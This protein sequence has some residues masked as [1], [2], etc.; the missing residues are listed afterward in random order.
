MG[1]WLVVVDAGAQMGFGFGRR[2]AA[3]GHGVAGRAMAKAVPLDA[4]Q[5]EGTA[6]A[7]A[8]R[9]AAPLFKSGPS[10]ALRALVMLGVSGLFCALLAQRLAEFDSA[11]LYPALAG[12][13]LSAWALAL[14]LTAVAFWA[15]GHY[16]AVLHRHFETGVDP[17][18]AR[19]AGVSAIAVSQT[20]GMG[21]VTGAILRWRMMPD[22]SLWLASRITV[23]VAMSFLAGWAVVTAAVVMA[24]GA[25]ALHIPAGA[26]LL[27]AALAAGYSV[28]ARPSLQLGFRWPNGFTILALITLCAVDTLAAAGALYALLPAD[29]G[30]SFFVLLPAFLIAYGA[31]LLSGAPGGIGAFELT[32]LALLPDLP[33][34]PILAAVVA[35]RSVYFVAPAILGAI[36]AMIGPR[37]A[38]GATDVPVA[39]SHDQGAKAYPPSQPAEFGLIAQGRHQ[40]LS[41]GGA[42]WLLARHSHSLVALLGPALL[43]QTD[44]PLPRAHRRLQ[45]MA[46][47]KDA[48]LASARWPAGYKWPA[49]MAVTARQMGWRVLRISREAVLNP[50]TFRLSAPACA[51]LRRKLRRAESA[52]LVVEF[53]PPAALPFAELDKIAQDWAADHGGERGFSMG[54]Y[55]RNYVTQQRVYLARRAN[56]VVGFITLHDNGREW[57]LDL[58]RHSADLPDGG[59]QALVCGAV[60]DA[61]AQGLARLSLA[62]VPEAAFA[63]RRRDG[64]DWRRAL[65]FVPPRALAAL[66]LDMGEGLRQFKDA[67]APNWEPRYLL[68]PHL[69]AL[70]LASLSIYRA[71]AFPQPLPKS[72]ASA[73]T[74]RRA[75][76][77]RFALPATIWH[78]KSN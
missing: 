39:Q 57:T 37:S 1:A 44:A 17:R 78:S 42:Q 63:P 7:N 14:G 22:R 60:Q 52:G 13:N 30:C 29:A 35:W 4:A 5:L 62:A 34:A 65:R 66:R 36:I 41:A 74:R 28:M 20:L 43:A 77:N 19:R 50:T 10:L 16:D 54:R 49:Q 24:L 8:P 68:A 12:V 11:A 27:T 61:A 38:A 18:A 21:V 76:H 73:D 75:W 70:L 25:P 67:F 26:V 15:V 56:H 9:D 72:K 23:A 53:C 31:G 64:T 47:L 2:A 6:L 3:R 71:I 55:A 59:M 45:A 58:M 32:L 46:A 48:A 69:P 40:V 33:E 51:G